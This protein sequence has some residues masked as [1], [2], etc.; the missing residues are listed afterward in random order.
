MKLIFPNSQRINRGGYVIKELVNACRENEVTDLVLLHEHRGR[1]DG[2]AICHFP[3]G[4]T[5]YFTLHNVVLRHDI[6]EKQPISE[7]YPQLIFDQFETKLG[8]RIQQILKHLFPVPKP[9]SQRVMTF[10]N[11]HDY[12]SFR[13]HVF[14]KDPDRPKFSEL[15][16][17]GPRFEAKPYEIKLGTLDMKEAETE[18]VYRPYHRNAKTRKLL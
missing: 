15:K 12:I 3:Y 14:Q 9:T 6:E 10:A 16:E 1:P 17:M 13:H 18:W 2:M 5:T 8:Q 11:Q 7:A 4:P